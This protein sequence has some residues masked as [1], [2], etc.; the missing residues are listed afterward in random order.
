MASKNKKV[1]KFTN[2]EHVT[3]RIVRFEKS[4]VVAEIT[5]GEEVAQLA[6]HLHRAPFKGKENMYAQCMILK[7]Q[8]SNEFCMWVGRNIDSISP[9]V[10]QLVADTIKAHGAGFSQIDRKPLAF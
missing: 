7:E 10:C 6:F 2:K 5:R 8:Q 1:N 4:Y 9:I 3:A